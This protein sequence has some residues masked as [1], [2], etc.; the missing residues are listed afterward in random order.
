MI[1]LESR[2]QYL[3]SNTLSSRTKLLTFMINLRSSL[4]LINISDPFAFF[5]N[6][7]I[8]NMRKVIMYIHHC[9]CFYYLFPI[10]ALIFYIYLKKS[11]LDI[12]LKLDPIPTFLSSVTT[13]YLLYRSEGDFDLFRSFYN[14]LSWPTS[15]LFL[16]FSKK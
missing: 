9:F 14:Y 11:F 2:K 3:S 15:F 1:H 8:K 10:F 7:L 16:G 6:F 5:V 4:S 13:V 12:C